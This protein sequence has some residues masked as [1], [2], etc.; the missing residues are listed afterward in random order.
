MKYSH[1]Y[2][3][4]KVS[5]YTTIRR[6]K[7]ANLHDIVVETFPSGCHKAQ[8]VKIERKALDDIYLTELLFDTDCN[9]RKEAY[10]LFQSFYKKPIDFKKELFY[11]YHLSVIQNLADSDQGGS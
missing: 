10:R 3:K 11:I 6:Y 8:V 4:L 5:N 9:S 7:K 1:N 2:A